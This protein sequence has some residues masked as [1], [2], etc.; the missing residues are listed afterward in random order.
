VTTNDNVRK[1]G[2]FIFCT[3]DEEG[4]YGLKK[5]QLKTAVEV[6]AIADSEMTIATDKGPI[7]DDMDD[8]DN[9]ECLFDVNMDATVDGNEAYFR[10]PFLS[11]DYLIADIV[12]VAANFPDTKVT[13]MTSN[14]ETT[15]TDDV[16]VKLGSPQGSEGSDSKSEER[17]FAKCAED[18]ASILGIATGAT[19]GVNPSSPRPT[20]ELNVAKIEYWASEKGKALRE[21]KF[22]CPEC[23]RN[24]PEHA[25]S[26]SSAKEEEEDEEHPKIFDTFDLFD[27]EKPIKVCLDAIRS[28]EKEYPDAL[29]AGWKKDVSTEIGCPRDWILNEFREN[30]KEGLRKQRKKHFKSKK[31]EKSSYFQC[32]NEFEE[33]LSFWD[34]RY[35]YIVKDNKYKVLVGA[36]H[37]FKSIKI[38]E[39]ENDKKSRKSTPE[40]QYGDT[41]STK[42]EPFAL[43][44]E[45]ECGQNVDA[46]ELFKEDVN[47]P[48]GNLIT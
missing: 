19:S 37:L 32:L 8:E 4:F 1:I 11:K 2:N 35:L 34:D 17:P 44:I 7:T 46:I 14:E 21:E 10:S 36:G 5:L 25:P 15:A 16:N 43:L 42:V 24:I 23:K 30:C 47:Y 38:Q 13:A 29:L 48:P 3:P 33:C 12:K 39:D 27:S 20:M 45:D 41:Y 9:I 28:W 40:V 26:C 6:G 22:L 18:I 31:D